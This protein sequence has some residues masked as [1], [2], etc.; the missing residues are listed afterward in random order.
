MPLKYFAGKV[1][2]RAG[3]LSVNCQ[4]CMSDLEVCEVRMNACTECVKACEDT[5]LCRQQCTS[6]RD[7]SS[8]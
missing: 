4:A 8:L 2:E 3:E 6:N 5:P 7:S 1:V